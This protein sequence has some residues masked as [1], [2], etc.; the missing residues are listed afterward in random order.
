M[1]KINETHLLMEL[2]LLMCAKYNNDENLKPYRM[3]T[4]AFRKLLRSGWAYCNRSEK[5]RL[6]RQYR[7]YTVQTRRNSNHYKQ[8]YH[9]GRGVFL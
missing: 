4:K 9:D 8:S 5:R 7:T 6:M 3:R 1:R 2:H